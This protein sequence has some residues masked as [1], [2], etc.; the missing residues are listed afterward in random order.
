MECIRKDKKS[1]QELLESSVGVSRDSI[2]GIRVVH[3][4]RFNGPYQHPTIDGAARLL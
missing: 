3:L 1:E 2:D 4:L